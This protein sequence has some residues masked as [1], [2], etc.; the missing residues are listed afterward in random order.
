MASRT[1]DYVRNLM[2]PALRRQYQPIALRVIAESGGRAQIARIRQAILARHPGSTWH[3]R[4]PIIVLAN[5]GIIEVKGTSVSFV[6]Q[7][8]PHQIASLLSA[9][10]ERAVRT[11]GLGVEDT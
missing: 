1:E 5:N 8:D 7:L 6:E 11:V 4:Y 3:R 2:R 9:L 10:D